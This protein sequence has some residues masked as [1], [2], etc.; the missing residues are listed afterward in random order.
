MEN[1]WQQENGEPWKYFWVARVELTF[2]PGGV[3]VLLVAFSNRTRLKFQPLCRIYPSLP[4]H[5]AYFSYAPISPYTSA[6]YFNKSGLQMVYH[7]PV[8]PLTHRLFSLR[9]GSCAWVW[10]F[11]SFSGHSCL[12]QHWQPSCLWK[13]LLTPPFKWIFWYWLWILKEVFLVFPGSNYRSDAISWTL[14]SPVR[15]IWETVFSRWHWCIVWCWILG[16]LKVRCMA[17]LSEDL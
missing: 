16:Q 9:E 17:G 11:G 7:L 10:L 12:L 8:R 2:H 6:R 5:I 13:Q 4:I 14:I 3:T 1:K 15:D